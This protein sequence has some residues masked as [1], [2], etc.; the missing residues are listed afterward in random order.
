MAPND[1]RMARVALGRSR[2]AADASGMQPPRRQQRS[3]L[4]FAKPTGLLA[5]LAL[6]ACSSEDADDKVYEFGPFSVAP[7]QEITAQCV[8]ITLHNTGPIYV[9]TVELTTGPGFH[10]SNW[11]FVPEHVFPGE[12]GSFACQ[13]RNFD[14]NA[15]AATGGV[16]FAQST[17]SLH[18][19]QAFPSGMAIPLP[20]NTKLI[21]QVHLLN[22]SDESLAIK[23]SIT[24]RQ[25]PESQV[26]RPLAGIS[27]SYHPLSLPPRKRSRFTADCDLE[28]YRDATK[29][30]DLNFNIYYT[31][32]HYHQY[33]TRMV[34]EAAKPDDT[35]ATI[36]T[37]SNSIGDALGGPLAPAFDMTGYSRLRLTC[38][39]YNNTDS[40]LY[41]GTGD[42][43]MCVFLAFSD[44]RWL[45]GGGVLDEAPDLA[46]GV[47][48]GGV[49]SFTRNCTIYT[50]EAY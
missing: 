21:A 25:L 24:L 8:Q 23:P 15:A 36:Y 31:L 32:A 45:W 35:L 38:E 30:R 48:D 4:G 20:P 18:E 42:G 22:R 1:S 39:Y 40:L 2:R 28:P 6:L 3:I 27:M 11:F 14:N 33:G 12:D 41:W 50:R 13:D 34:L 26:T 10:H 19:V 47:D 43:E 9:N 49:I 44:S 29:D 7:Q 5:L 46:S 37:T 16:L 17:Q